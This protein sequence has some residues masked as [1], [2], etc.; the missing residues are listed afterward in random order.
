MLKEPWFDAS[1]KSLSGNS[2]EWRKDDEIIW[3]QQMRQSDKFKFYQRAFDF[4][5]TN[6]II[7]DYIEFGCHRCRTFRMAMTEAKRHFLDHMSFYAF[8]SFEGLPEGITDHEV[9][10]WR[11]GSLATSE[12]E[13]KQLII[14]SGFSLSNVITVKGFYKDTLKDKAK[15]PFTGNTKAS[16][17]NIDCDYY[18]SAVP[19]FEIL[20]LLVQEGTILYIDDY[21]SGYRGNPTK[22][23][24]K[25]M[26]GWESQSSW[27]LEPYHYVGYGGRSFIIY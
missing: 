13:F 23:V 17:I 21:Y 20:D 2:T 22:G 14:S 15:F 27:R 3:N 16:M 11:G 9:Q 1:L 26:K 12:E 25:A 19:V 24:S 10:E 6:E 5:S 18:E 4:I 7:G 8:D